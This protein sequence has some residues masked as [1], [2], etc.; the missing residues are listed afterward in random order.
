MNKGLKILLAILLG[1]YI[2]SPV[3]LVSACPI[4]DII[5]LLIAVASSRK[6]SQNQR[7]ELIEDK[8]VNVIDQYPS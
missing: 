8:D 4:D 2:I 7:R 3:D 5:I 1:A 6:L